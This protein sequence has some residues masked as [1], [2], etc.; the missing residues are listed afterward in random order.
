VWSNPELT[1]QHVDPQAAPSA[2]EKAILE[3]KILIVKGTLD[4]VFKTAMKQRAS[5]HP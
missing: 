2:G 1:C 5:L 4:D 3:T